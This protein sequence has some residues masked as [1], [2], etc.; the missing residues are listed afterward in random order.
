VTRVYAVWGV[1]SVGIACCVGNRGGET[2]KKRGAWEQ[3][4]GAAAKVRLSEMPLFDVSVCVCVC[5]FDGRDVRGESCA[6]WS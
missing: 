1:G 3:T 6:M 4:G 2:T 5:V